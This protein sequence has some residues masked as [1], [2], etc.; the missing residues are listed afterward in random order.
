M[1]HLPCN[2]ADPRPGGLRHGGEAAGTGG[3]GVAD[4]EGRRTGYDEDEGQTGHGTGADDNARGGLEGG[5]RDVERHRRDGTDEGRRQ[6]HDTR[7]HGRRHPDR[8]LRTGST[9]GCRRM[10]DG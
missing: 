5:Q 3:A 10:D 1:V 7:H 6:L 4:G 8:R 9:V 2:D